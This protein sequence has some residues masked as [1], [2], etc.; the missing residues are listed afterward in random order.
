MGPTDLVVYET[1]EA[2][3]NVTGIACADVHSILSRWVRRVPH[4]ERPDVLQDIAVEALR[5]RPTTPGLLFA[6]AGGRVRDW[7]KR[8][9]YRQ[10]ESLD[11]GTE[12]EDGEVRG[13][14]ADNVPGTVL[15]VEFEAG[16]ISIPVVITATEDFEDQLC[17][18][19]DAKE[20]WHELPE[21][22]QL[23]VGKR[24]QG[25]PLSAADRQRL[26]RWLGKRLATRPGTLPEMYPSSLV[27]LH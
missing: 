1:A 20:L 11:A 27:P 15:D 13:T 16:G 6:V 25:L 7:F 18:A 23:A 3:S 26:R 12:G 10:H 24:L 14:N 21:P 9:R 19:I 2:L 5:A 22:I 8:E 17:S 4:Q